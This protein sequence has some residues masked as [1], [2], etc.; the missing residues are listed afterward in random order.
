MKVNLKEKLDLIS[1]FWTP[2]IIGELNLQHVKLAKIKGEFIMHHHEHEDEL[3]YVIKGKM[4]MEFEDHSEEINEGEFIIIPKGTRH[5][6]S[7]DQETHILLFEPNTTLNTGNIE[8][9]F[10][11]KSPERK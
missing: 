8:N 9:K 1:D 7:A 2:V 6:P 10:T 3:F 5:R 11:V 4:K